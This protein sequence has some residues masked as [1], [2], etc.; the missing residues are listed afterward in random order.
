MPMTTLSPETPELQPDRGEAPYVRPLA[1][2][3]EAVCRELATHRV[4]AGNARVHLPGPQQALCASLELTRPGLPKRVPAGWH[5]EL[6]WWAEPRGQTDRRYLPGSLVP[7]PEVVAEFLAFG[8]E[9]GST[10]PVPHRYRL[11]T[12][13]PDLL[14][15]LSDRLG[16]DRG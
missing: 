15:L 9:Q 1:R 13:G 12:G 7:P 3:L 4:L 10:S 2:Y 14:A 5:E 11:L 6:G 8:A 16:G